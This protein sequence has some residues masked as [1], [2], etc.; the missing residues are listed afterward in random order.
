MAEAKQPN[1]ET[2]SVVSDEC[3]HELLEFFS[4]SSYKARSAD[5]RV[6]LS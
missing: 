5:R 2:D 6:S 4:R 3:I 1:V